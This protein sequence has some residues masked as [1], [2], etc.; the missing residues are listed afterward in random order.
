MSGAATTRTGAHACL[1]AAFALAVGAAGAG[2]DS[3]GVGPRGDDGRGGGCRSVPF[4]ER[5]L[6]R[7][8]CGS[9][10]ETLNWLLRADDY[11]VELA[12]RFGGATHDSVRRLQSRNGLR[13]S[14]VVNRR[15]RRAIVAGM[16]RQK[17]SWYGPGFFGNRTACGQRLR[18]ETVGVA[19][20]TLP[21]GARVVFGY[22]GRFV[23]TRVIDRGPFVK[24]ARYERDWDLTEALAKRLR[25][26]GVD[27]VRAAPV[28]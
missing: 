2:A 13:R 12:P 24:R 7:G 19:H 14:G 17:A 8:D 11:G 27:R 3:G 4:G 9:D 22:G 18:R 10:V 21:C 25:F 26:E 23:R 16:R 5:S 6:E 15:T 28:R 20:R 1:A